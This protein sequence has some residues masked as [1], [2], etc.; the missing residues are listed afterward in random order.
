[1]PE[2][3]GTLGVYWF[4]FLILTKTED[5]ISGLDSILEVELVS[6]IHLFKSIGLTVLKSFSPEVV[7]VV[8]L[9]RVDVAV[10]KSDVSND[11]IEESYGSGNSTL[12]V[13]G[14]EELKLND[15]LEVVSTNVGVRILSSSL[16]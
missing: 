2:K 16:G 13:V 7:N 12:R 14:S 9:L 10:V 1:M 8:E 3:S 15:L 5:R 4:V 6:E 11:D